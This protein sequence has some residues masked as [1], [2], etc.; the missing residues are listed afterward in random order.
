[1]MLRQMVP[2]KN[3]KFRQKER[4]RGALDGDDLDRILEE[5]QNVTKSRADKAIGSLVHG[6]GVLQTERKYDLLAPQA[7]IVHNPVIATL[8]VTSS[9]GGRTRVPLQSIGI[10]LVPLTRGAPPITHTLTDNKDGSYAIEFEGSIQDVVYQLQIDIYNQR[11][12]DWDVKICGPPEPR[13][14]IAEAD[15]KGYRVNQK[16]DV[17]LFSRDK[18]GHELKVGGSKVGL[19]FNGSGQLTNVGLVDRMDGTYVLSFIPNA[20]GRYSVWLTLNGVD[21]K[22]C[23]LEFSVK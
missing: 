14:C 22:T 20:P 17:I 3:P 19:S 18:N 23:P 5:I 4:A 10:K 2:E 1:M 16:G 9:T 12:F 11:Q 6:W 21:I 8:I 7:A 15:P 13:Q